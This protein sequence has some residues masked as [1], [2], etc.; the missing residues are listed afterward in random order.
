MTY[1]TC[2]LTAKN[3]D[4]LRNPTLS[5]RVWA[6]FLPPSQLRLIL[7]DHGITKS[8]IATPAT[9]HQTALSG[10]ADRVLSAPSLLS[11]LHLGQLQHPRSNNTLSN[12][13][14]QTGLYQSNPGLE[15]NSNFTTQVTHS[16]MPAHC[17]LCWSFCVLPAAAMLGCQIVRLSRHTCEHNKMETFSDR[18]ALVLFSLL[19]RFLSPPLLIFSVENRPTPF[20][21]WMS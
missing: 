19:F 7:P 12:N 17:L 20:P 21:G 8:C 9:I 3:Q 13:R 10:S 6:I 2:R 1:V 11:G 4:R 16:L 15:K 18:L 5:Y 14:F